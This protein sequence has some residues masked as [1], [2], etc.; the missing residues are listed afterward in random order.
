MINKR[1]EIII[2]AFPRDDQYCNK[3]YDSLEEYNIKAIKG[4]RGLKWLYNNRR[5]IDGIH[6]HWPSFYYDRKRIFSI[7]RFYIFLCYVKILNKKII[8]T[9]HNLYPHYTSRVLITDYVMRYI[10]V[11]LSDLI[12]VHGDNSRKTVIKEFPI[13]AKPK[14]RVIE[15]GN[16]IESVM[17]NIDV[18]EARKKLDLNHSEF[19]YLSLGK[20]NPYKGLENL[21][22]A[23]NNVTDGNDKM[24]IA[25]KFPK[26]EYYHSIVSKIKEI[27]PAGERIILMDRRIDDNELQ[28]FMNAANVMVLPYKKR[29]V[30]SSGI[31]LMSLSFG[32]P[33]I[34]PAIGNFVDLLKSDSVG[35]LYGKDS[36]IK[37]LSEAMRIAKEMHFD[38]DSIIEYAKMYDWNDIGRKASEYLRLII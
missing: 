32:L 16:Y 29:S 10:L 7:V 38:K 8:W 4:E 13:A 21:L 19:V 2:A 1:K 37:D 24:I 27:D 22:V 36:C 20:A 6:I 15:H 5:N 30:M 33:I 12:F 35:V 9:L 3:F 34:A 17:N 18:E 25:G 28:T 31:A 11:L 23:Y 14:I 26:K